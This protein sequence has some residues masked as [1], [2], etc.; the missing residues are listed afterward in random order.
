MAGSGPGRPR[1]CEEVLV[2]MWYWSGGMHWWGWLLGTVGMVA[3]WGLI[4]W[5]VWYFVTGGSRPTDQDGRSPGDA[6][7][8]L[9]ERLARGEIEPDEYRRLRDLISGDDAGIRDGQPPVGTGGRR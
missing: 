7:R 6:R 3:F 4:I 1:I 8:I 9:D 5:A 2:M